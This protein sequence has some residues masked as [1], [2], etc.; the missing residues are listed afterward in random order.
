MEADGPT[1]FTRNPVPLEHHPLP[2]CYSGPHVTSPTG[3]V[4]T[5]PASSAEI[6]GGRRLPLGATLL[7]HRLLAQQGWRMVHVETEQW[8]R[9]RGPEAKRRYLLEAGVG[10][11]LAEPP[12]GAAPGS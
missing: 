4:S 11:A 7:K 12:T 2:G 1:H 6:S 5:G 3:Q 9:L 10:A 8:E